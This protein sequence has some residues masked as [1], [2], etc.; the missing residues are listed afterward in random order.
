MSTCG[1]VEFEWPREKCHNTIQHPRRYCER[2]VA[3]MDMLCKDGH[4][5]AS[6]DGERS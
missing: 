2:V 4:A 3:L 6:G 1:Y 5:L